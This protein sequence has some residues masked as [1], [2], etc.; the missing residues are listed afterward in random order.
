MS[1]VS[2]M[3]LSHHDH[4]HTVSGIVVSQYCYLAR[5]YEGDQCDEDTPVL[6]PS[7]QVSSQ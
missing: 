4:N 1:H 5:R 2:Y 6:S 3:S 7:H